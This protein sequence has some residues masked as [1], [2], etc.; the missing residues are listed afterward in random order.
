MTNAT[1]Y[2]AAKARAFYAGFNTDSFS[3]DGAEQLA[4]H[5]REYWQKRGY[6]ADVRVESGWG[7]MPAM[8]T[9]KWFVIRSDMVNGR[10][11]RKLKR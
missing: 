8:R 6:A 2:G 10:P 1:T 7:F 4:Q 3:K 9:G 5:I 11:R